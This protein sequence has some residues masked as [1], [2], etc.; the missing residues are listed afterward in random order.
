MPTGEIVDMPDNPTPELLAQLAAI[1]APQQATPDPRYA[2]MNPVQRFLSDKP[3]DDPTLANLAQG[4][5]LA[6]KALTQGVTSSGTMIADP[7]IAMANMATGSNMRLPSQGISKA[8]PKARNT[9]ERVMETLG[10]MLAGSRDPL[11]NAATSRYLPPATSRIPTA[12][13]DAI[14]KGQQL[15][16]KVPPSESTGGVIGTQLERTAGKEPLYNTMALENQ[17]LT[18]KLSRQVVGLAPGQRITQEA[19]DTA[20]KATY[21]AGY[22][23][24]K[25]IGT[26]TTGKTYR[27]ALD[28]VLTDFQG[29]PGSFPL[30]TKNDVKGL[31]DAYRVRSFDSSHAIEAIQNLRQDATQSFRSGNP[32]LGQ[33][34]SA[35][36]KALE[37]NVEQNLQG[38]GQD[39]A[40]M[41]AEF[42]ASR[43]Q[44][45]KQNV[46]AKALEKGTGE[47][48]A[49]KI[50]GMLKRNGENY[51][52]DK[53]S[54][55]G[56]FAANAQKVTKVPQMQS[57]PVYRH[58]IGTALGTAGLASL[59]PGGQ[60]PAAMIAGFPLGQAGLRQAMMSSTAQRMIGPQLDPNILAR[61][62]GNP[63]VINALP[64][65]LEQTGL[66]GPR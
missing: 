53:L 27:Q 17:N 61:L 7:L 65:G 26:I 39:G 31:V 9:T 4:T 51:L 40:K 29:A 3:F 21:A 19:I 10:S 5:G 18:D 50:A 28:K 57:V 46:I 1:Q 23:P 6:A 62:A 8:F 34:Q 66:F 47:V 54:T 33:A 36:A 49:Q 45:A 13:E 58:P 16:Y 2:A 30:A 24:I 32:N 35:V 41:L 12:R 59:I 55:I 52:T 56:N 42:R 22:E 38:M 64:T 60:I 37:N 20:K 14:L 44:L 15:G 25:A 11:M 63:S 43:V 48:N